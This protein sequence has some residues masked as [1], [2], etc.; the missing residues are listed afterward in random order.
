MQN[1]PTRFGTLSIVAIFPL[2]GPAFCY[3]QHESPVVF[4]QHPV[5]N[6]KIVGI[7]STEILW[8]IKN[9]MEFPIEFMT[10][11]ASCGCA[12]ISSA[13]TRLEPGE[14]GKIRL[15][16]SVGSRQEGPVVTRSSTAF[17]VGAT[18]RDACDSASERL[19]R[20]G[21]SK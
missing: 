2:W 9:T 20:Q 10:A 14:F 8:I 13:I 18:F 21:N 15:Q 7:D 16:V 19:L 4:D 12:S 6:A 11:S 5:G 17:R 3:A 1:G